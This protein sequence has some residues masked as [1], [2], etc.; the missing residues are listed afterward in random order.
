MIAPRLALPVLDEGDPAA[1]RVAFTEHVVVP[2][3][4]R[5]KVE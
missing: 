3:V 5:L 2:P 1:P 4:K